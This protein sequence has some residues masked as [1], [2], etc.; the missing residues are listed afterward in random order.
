MYDNVVIVSRHKAA[1]EFVAGT[2]RTDC[3]DAQVLDDRIALY[4]MADTPYAGT[5]YGSIRVITGNAVPDDVAG[6]V[7]IG[8]VPLSLAALAERVDTIEFGGTPPRGQDY[9]L[10]EMLAAG[11]HL[12]SYT[13]RLWQD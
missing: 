2:F 13:V 3:M 4:G 12:K 10:T 5:D 6:K 9:S 8:N 11:A 7:V 1:L